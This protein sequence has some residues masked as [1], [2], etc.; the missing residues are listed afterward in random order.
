MGG[1]GMVGSDDLALPYPWLMWNNITI[2]GQRMSPRDCDPAV[3]G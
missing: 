2:K 1:V 3:T